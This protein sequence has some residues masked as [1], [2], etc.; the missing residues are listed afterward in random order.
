MVYRWLVDTQE[1]DYAI[2]DSLGVSNPVT[3]GFLR[4]VQNN[5]NLEMIAS[6]LFEAYTTILTNTDREGT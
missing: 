4:L 5:M 3:D 2:E 1:Y 6:L